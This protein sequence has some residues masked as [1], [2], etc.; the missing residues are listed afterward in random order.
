MSNNIQQ[1][2][3]MAAEKNRELQAR[4]WKQIE[5]NQLYNINVKDAQLVVEKTKIL[6]IY[7]V[8]FGAFFIV[9]SLASMVALQVYGIY[10]QYID[11]VRVTNAAHVQNVSG[12]SIA[13]CLHNRFFATLFCPSVN[14]NFAEAL[15]YMWYQQDMRDTM[16]STFGSGVLMNDE[17]DWT[18]W[19]GIWRQA[20]NQ[21]VLCALRTPNLDALSLACQS[22][23][24]LSTGEL[25]QICY[26][27]C[28]F[29]TSMSGTNT[30]MGA[31][32]GA[33]GMAG[34][35]GGMGMMAGGPAGLAMAGIGLLVGGIMGGIQANQ[36]HQEWVTHCKNNR[37]S[38]KCY[39][40]KTFPSCS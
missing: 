20:V 11:L 23:N 30:G 32:Q 15:W 18:G 25:G 27:T 5:E 6:F 8:L 34:S 22:V 24:A 29:P 14:S 38:G 12:F 33:L 9:V 37:D 2:N 16:L 7:K 35:L 31:A 36:R 19:V 26:P 39:W 17:T 4:A 21:C 10:K 28:T 1:Q 3:T 13:M 40:P